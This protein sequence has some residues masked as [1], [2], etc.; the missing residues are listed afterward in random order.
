MRNKTTTQQKHEVGAI[1][2]EFRDHKSA[3]KS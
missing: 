3:P 1:W 2:A